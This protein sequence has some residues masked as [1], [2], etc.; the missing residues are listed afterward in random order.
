MP[1]I[2]STD[3]LFL[4]DLFEMGKGYVLNFS[5]RTS[6]QFF[7]EELNVSIDDPQHTRWRVQG[8]AGQP[9]A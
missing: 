2:R 4:D 5:D 3:M 8:H 1:D 6:A 9:R 7:A